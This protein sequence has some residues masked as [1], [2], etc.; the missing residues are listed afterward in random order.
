MSEVRFAITSLTFFNYSKSGDFLSRYAKRKRKATDL[1]GVVRS[2]LYNGFYVQPGV[3][4]QKFIF[5]FNL[6]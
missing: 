4:G 6:N 1:E 5:R 2:V 3:K